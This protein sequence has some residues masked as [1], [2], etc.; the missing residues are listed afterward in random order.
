MRNKAKRCEISNYYLGS[1]D[2]ND[3]FSGVKIELKFN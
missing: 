1:D 2:F 3:Y